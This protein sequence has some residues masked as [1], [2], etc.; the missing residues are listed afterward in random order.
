[1]KTFCLFWI[2]SRKIRAS[3][4]RYHFSSHL[5]QTTSLLKELL[6]RHTKDCYEAHP[7]Y[8]Q[9]LQF[10]TEMTRGREDTEMNDF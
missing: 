8:W 1:M 7:I 6:P 4:E 3:K 5:S 9:A 2:I 10:V